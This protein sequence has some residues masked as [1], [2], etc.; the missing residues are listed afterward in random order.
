MATILGSLSWTSSTATSSTPKWL[1]PLLLRLSI[2][3]ALAHDCYPSYFWEEFFALTQMNLKPAQCSIT[4]LREREREL[5]V[6]NAKRVIKAAHNLAH[7]NV[8]NVQLKQWTQCT[9]C[10]IYWANLVLVES[11]RV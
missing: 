6:H 9:Q 11:K 2:A 10:E 7:K 3:N 4:A 1:R 8:L 5:P